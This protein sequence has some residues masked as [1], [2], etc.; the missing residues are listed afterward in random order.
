MEITVFTYI[1]SRYLHMKVPSSLPSGLAM[2]A[3]QH[4]RIW[5][6]I[7]NNL[8][9]YRN[10]EGAIYTSPVQKLF[11]EGN[12]KPNHFH[13][14]INCSWLRYVHITAFFWRLLS[15]ILVKSVKIVFSWILPF[16]KALSFHLNSSIHSF[17]SLPFHLSDHTFLSQLL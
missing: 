7:Q 1:N 10:L 5:K 12:S 9:I 13:Y 3:K 16:P 11:F 6:W 2:T 15:R 4:G 17:L 8:K 14:W